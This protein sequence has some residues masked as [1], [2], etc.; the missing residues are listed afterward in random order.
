MQRVLPARF[1]CY[2]YLRSVQVLR[3]PIVARKRRPLL[4][5]VLH[6]FRLHH[7]FQRL[8]CRWTSG[9]TR[10]ESINFLNGSVEGCEEF[11]KALSSGQDVFQLVQGL[12]DAE[13]VEMRRHQD[14]HGAKQI[15]GR[16]NSVSHINVS[17][18][19]DDSCGSHLQAQLKVETMLCSWCKL[20]TTKGTFDR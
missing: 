11:G 7:A 17:G 14:A 18:D 2:G 20:T 13:H 1:P 12:V 10:H 4:L 19:W 9:A 5:L 8:K 3:R 16:A 15:S 6:V